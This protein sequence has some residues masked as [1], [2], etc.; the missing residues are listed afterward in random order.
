MILSVNGMEVASQRF[1][2]GEADWG[3][4]IRLDGSDSERV[5][6]EGVVNGVWVYRRAL[7]VMTVDT[8]F[9]SRE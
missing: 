1:T 4:R 2:G 6:A 8:T 9:R 5:R 7:N 3:D